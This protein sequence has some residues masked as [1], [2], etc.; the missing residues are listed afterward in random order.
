MDTSDA[1]SPGTL[2]TGAAQAAYGHACVN[3]A[4][5]KC[6]CILRVD[7]S[8]ICERC[9]RLGKQ[10]V[11]S[12]T[13]RKS[14]HRARETIKAQS[15]SNRRVQELEE[16]LLELTSVVRTVQQEQQ[17]HGSNHSNSQGAVSGTG[18]NQNLSDFNRTIPNLTPSSIS[19][20]ASPSSVLSSY[21]EGPSITPQEAVACL[22]TFR[23]QHLQFFPMVYLPDTLTPQQLH[24][25]RPFLW[26]V[27][28]AICSKSIE[29][30]A[31]L[32]TQIRE[33]LAR[34]LIIE[35]ERSVDYLSGLSAFL[36]W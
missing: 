3:C 4:R 5:A 32:A 34:Q 28:R 24:H 11:P 9:H 33:T 7:N 6:R 26:S 18:S 22:D 35:G 17:N 19:T 30:Q 2:P 15:S 27:I 13:V 20:G 16:K 12:N 31:I 23:T 10:C 14:T 21:H 36:A 8:N 29:Q 1:P 25:D